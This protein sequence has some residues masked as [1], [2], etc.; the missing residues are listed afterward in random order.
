VAV[1]VFAMTVLS[2][3]INDQPDLKKELKTIIEDQLPYASPGFVA[4]ARK[5]IKKLV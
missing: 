4:R 2:T 1:K 3:I 5:I